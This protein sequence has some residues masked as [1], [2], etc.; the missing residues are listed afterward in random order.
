MLPPFVLYFVLVLIYFIS[1]GRLVHQW[2][3]WVTGGPSLRMR[4][5]GAFSLRH[6]LRAQHV[7]S[8]S[9][10]DDSP[11]STAKET[12]RVPCVRAYSLFNVHYVSQEMHACASRHWHRK[13]FEFLPT[14]GETVR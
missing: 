13:V 12:G 5:V 2:P 10:S 3:A 1:K 9:L 4:S 11:P 7:L 6:L 8:I 14:I